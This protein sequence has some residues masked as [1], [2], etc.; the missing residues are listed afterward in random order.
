[1]F[2]IPIESEAR[3]FCD[4]KSVVNS[5]TRPD[6]RL[7]QKHKSIAFHKIRK[8]VASGKALIYF[9]NSESNLAG[10]LTKVLSVKKRNNFIYIL[11]G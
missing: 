7:K 5:G 8:I 10:L 11:L 2:G 6:C 3:V 1:M 9:E 4:N